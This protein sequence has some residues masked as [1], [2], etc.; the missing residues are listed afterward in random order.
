MGK[1]RIK[2]GE[3]MEKLVQQ[4]FKCALTGVE[5]ESSM[6]VPDHRLPLSRGGKHRIENIDIVHVQANRAK[7]DMTTAE[8]VDLCE[9]VVETAEDKK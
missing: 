8:F 9:R 7:G 1:G 5:L 2:A 4:K 6:A 3:L